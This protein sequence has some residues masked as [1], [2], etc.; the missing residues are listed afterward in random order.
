M[1]KMRLFTKRLATFSVLAVFLCTAIVTAQTQ[2]QV[3]S[4]HVTWT[5][6]EGFNECYA[7]LAGLVQNRVLWFNDQ[8]LIDNFAIGDRW[9]YVTE[10][11]APDPRDYTLAFV[12]NFTFDDP[13]GIWWNVTEWQYAAPAHWEKVDAPD[14]GNSGNIGNDVTTVHGGEQARVG[15]Y[16]V[17]TVKV[18]PL[19]AEDRHRGPFTDHS[20]YN[21][22]AVIDI[23]KFVAEANAE[24]DG[25][26]ENPQSQYDP[27][28]NSEYPYRP[29]SGVDPT[30]MHKTYAAD[31]SLGLK[32]KDGGILVPLNEAGFDHAYG[33]NDEFNAI[34]P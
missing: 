23:C 12:R 32:P 34:T 4:G 16:Y 13:N 24:V 30:H 26:E 25:W 20:L 15:L 17:W 28:P 9:I 21:F 27:S 31:V 7:G 19:P 3:V 2:Q 1:L 33:A 10:A 29:A 14:T 6:L 8:V 18:L 11:G 22:V 5:T